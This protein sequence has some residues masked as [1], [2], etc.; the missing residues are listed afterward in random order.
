[1]VW[2]STF[3]SVFWITLSGIITGS[4]GL[5]IRYSLKSKCDLVKVC[6]GLLEIHRNVELENNNNDIELS[7]DGNK[8]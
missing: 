1:M 6:W 2:Y 5:C 8:V 4:I 3:D 7:S